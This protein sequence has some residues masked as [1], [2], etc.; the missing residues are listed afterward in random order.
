MNN[1]FGDIE[2]V[3]CGLSSVEVV[4]GVDVYVHDRLMNQTN[5]EKIMSQGE[6]LRSTWRIFFPM[7]VHFF[8][9][10]CHTTI[11]CIYWIKLSFPN[12]SIS[13]GLYHQ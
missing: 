2:V 9:H 4:G 5:S 11:Y 13:A 6:N 8:M 1:G 10:C 3:Q 12:S 7:L